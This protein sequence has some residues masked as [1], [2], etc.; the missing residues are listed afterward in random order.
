M[1]KKEELLSVDGIC[2][3]CCGKIH[4]SSIQCCRSVRFPASEGL[5]TINIL[6]FLFNLIKTAILLSCLLGLLAKIQK[7]PCALLTLISFPWCRRLGQQSL[8]LWHHRNVSVVELN[9]ECSWPSTQNIELTAE[10]WGQSIVSK[11]VHPMCALTAFQ[12]PLRGPW[13]LWEGNVG[14]WTGKESWHTP[15]ASSCSSDWE[16][17]TAERTAEFPCYMAQKSCGDCNGVLVT[18]TGYLRACG[19]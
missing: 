15:V 11:H 13:F 19:S 10:V 7:E 9:L 1:T 18:V 17:Q 6:L 8:E 4:P 16:S 5:L 2:A 14:Q 12:F 3:A